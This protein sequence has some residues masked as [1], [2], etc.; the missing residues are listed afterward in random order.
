MLL[1]VESHPAMLIYLDNARSLGPDSLAGTRTRRGL[2]ENLARE[3][4]ELHTWGVRSTYTQEDVFRFANAITG[5]TV[6]PPRQDPIRGGEFTFNARMHQPGVQ[7][8][9]GTSYSDRGM[10]QGRDVLSARLPDI[11]RLRRTLQASSPVISSP[12]R[13]PL[14]WSSGYPGASSKPKAI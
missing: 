5:W 4:L 7:M 10:E 11:P 1:A 8:V 14:R 12:T 6:I 2:N 3:I 9:L 13:H